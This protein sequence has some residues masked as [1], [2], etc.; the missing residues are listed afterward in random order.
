[1]SNFFRNDSTYSNYPGLFETDYYLE[2][3]LPELL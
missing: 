1:M 3:E 2:E